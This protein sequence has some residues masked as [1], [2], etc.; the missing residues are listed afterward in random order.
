LVKADSSDLVRVWLLDLVLGFNHFRRKF[1]R[2]EPTGESEAKRSGK[3]P[4]WKAASTFS[5]PYPS[6]KF[7]FQRL[8]YSEKKSARHFTILILNSEVFERVDGGSGWRAKKK[9][10]RKNNAAFSSK[11]PKGV[12]ESNK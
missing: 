10:R 8:I 6:S 1:T 11:K 5:D 9:L 4:G 3:A 12:N 7:S 2:R